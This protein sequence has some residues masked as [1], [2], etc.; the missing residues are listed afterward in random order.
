MKVEIED[1]E[2]M[3]WRDF[4]LY[5][6]VPIEDSLKYT[7][8]WLKKHRDKVDREMRE[9]Y[10]DVLKLCTRNSFFQFG[11]KFYDQE[12]G[13]AMGSVVGPFVASDIFLGKKKI[14]QKKFGEVYRR[15]FY[16]Y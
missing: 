1:D 16:A 3:V 8:D 7:D 14:S 4:F 10:I 15:R 11:G 2:I 5:P 13:A 9:M 12:D 6:N